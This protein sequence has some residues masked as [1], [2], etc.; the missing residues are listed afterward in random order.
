MIKSSEWISVKDRLPEY[1]CEVITYDAKKHVAQT[2]GYS[3][4]W[5]K[6]NASDCLDHC[7]NA[8]DVTHWM[9]IPDLPED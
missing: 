8:I 6:F 5:G 9:P 1:S 3:K 4:K 7:N 2:L